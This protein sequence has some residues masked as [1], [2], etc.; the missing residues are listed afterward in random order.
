MSN[1]QILIVIWIT[2][3]AT[4]RVTKVAFPIQ[5]LRTRR[6]CTEWIEFLRHSI[7][8]YIHFSIRACPHRLVSLALLHVNKLSQTEC[9]FSKNE[10][11]VKD[12]L[13]SII[14]FNS[15]NPPVKEWIQGLWPTLYRSSGTR[16][17]I[18]QDIVFGS[19]KPKSLQ[20]ILVHTN[21]YGNSTKK[22]KQPPKCKQRNCR[23][24]PLINKTGEVKPI[25]L[26]EL[27]KVW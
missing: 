19:R 9:M 20:G 17:L 18:D 3:L 11:T 14:E 15:T 27:I 7:Q 10:D 25:L 26:I 21:I 1:Q 8:L 13:Y 24:C 16:T 5:F 6:N 4:L 22:K 12:A 2:I 23:H